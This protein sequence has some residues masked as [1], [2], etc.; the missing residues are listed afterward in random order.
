[1]EQGKKKQSVKVSFDF[2][3]NGMPFSDVFELFESMGLDR[4]VDEMKELF[5]F[6]KNP[7]LMEAE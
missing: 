2:G 7:E 3:D 5:P 6:S 4:A 1:M